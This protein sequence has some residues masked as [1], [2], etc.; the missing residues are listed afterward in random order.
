[1]A[2]L[3]K[4]Y[5][6][7]YYDFTDYFQQNNNIDYWKDENHLSKTG[8]DKFSVVLANTLKNDLK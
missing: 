7:K 1:M 6:L 8:A 5:D 3:M 4:E 2:N